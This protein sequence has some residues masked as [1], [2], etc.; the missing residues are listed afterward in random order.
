MTPPPAS[1][2]LRRHL[3]LWLCLLGTVP[4]FV[5]N[6]LPTTTWLPGVESFRWAWLPLGPVKPAALVM[7]VAAC[8]IG[9]RQRLRWQWLAVLPLLALALVPSDRIGAAQGPLHWIERTGARALDVQLEPERQAIER[10]IDPRGRL[11]TLASNLG[12]PLPDPARLRAMREA[13]LAPGLKAREAAR[14]AAL[15]PVQAKRQ[16]IEQQM[17]QLPA[18]LQPMLRRSLAPALQQLDAEERRI[19]RQTFA[20]PPPSPA[21]MWDLRLALGLQEM[22]QG[23]RQARWVEAPYRLAS[24]LLVAAMVVLL[25]IGHRVTLAFLGTAAIASLARAWWIDDGAGAPALLKGAQPVVVGTLALLVLR[26]L[27]RGWRDNVEIWRSTEPTEL[28]RAL[29]AALLLWSPFAVVL[30]VHFQAGAWVADRVEQRL[31]CQTPAGPAAPCPQGGLLHDSDPGRDTL[32][33]DLLIAA[34][35]WYGEFEWAALA[36][37]AGTDAATDAGASKARDRVLGAFDAVVKPEIFQYPGA[38]QRAPCGLFQPLGCIGNIPLDAANAA[39]QRLR[40]RMVQTLDE[41]LQQ[42]TRGVGQGAAAASSRLAD[43]VRD[44]AAQ[45]SRQTREQADAALLAIAAASAFGSA[46]LLFVAA[47]AY[48]LV[49][50]RVLF[51][52]HA[53]PG[54][55]ITPDERPIDRGAAPVPL[56]LPNG[57]ELRLNLQHDPLLMKKAFDVDGAAPNTLWLPVQP[58]HAAPTRLRNRCYWLK[59]IEATAAPRDLTLKSTPGTNFFCWRLPEDAEVAFRWDRF[60]GMSAGVQLRRVFSLKLG[61]LVLGHVM[62]TMAR[63][64]GVLVQHAYTRANASRTSVSQARVVGWVVGSPFRVESGRSRKNVYIDHCHVVCVEPGRAVHE[65]AHEGR[66]G[67]GLW[68][69]LLGLVRL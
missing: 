31:Y 65:A 37:L 27:V 7:L 62:V 47:R 17:R 33:E 30:G 3:F 59:E 54:M 41:R 57:D 42:A 50:A 28:R 20:T 2:D 34:A 63:G 32:R 49:L 29:L 25:G 12:P 15:R 24:G 5:T 61:T 16:Q 11:A 40:G 35:R 51:A 56:D 23:N 46:L 38:P 6:T 13:V 4:A 36:A 48:L 21:A 55:T 43:A 39:Y 9:W 44:Q 67:G 45:A 64:P 53:R 69:E 8:A 52:H 68:R 60:A 26:V 18:H 10:L 1:A 22:W 58:W 66:T 19:E 14:Q